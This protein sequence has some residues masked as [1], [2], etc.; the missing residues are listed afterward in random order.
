MFH[1][2]LNQ[3]P[4]Y[5]NY[6]S[7]VAVYQVFVRLVFVVEECCFGIIVPQLEMLLLEMLL[8]E[9]VAVAALVWCC[10]SPG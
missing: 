9:A 4:T 5:S 6:C 7:A 10:R 2:G 3:V 8:G 1:V